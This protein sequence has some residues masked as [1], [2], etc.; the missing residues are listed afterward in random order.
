MQ[1][2]LLREALDLCVGDART[3]ERS[4]EDVLIRVR[5]VIQT[6]P[7]GGDRATSLGIGGRSTYDRLTTRLTSYA[8]TQYFATHASSATP[9]N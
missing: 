7:I 9:K 4:C 2:G 6:S 1:E 3:S 8:L 5:D